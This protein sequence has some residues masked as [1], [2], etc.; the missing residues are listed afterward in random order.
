[1]AM[2]TNYL[3]LGGLSN[4]SGVKSQKLFSLGLDQAVVRVVLHF[5]M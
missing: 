5:A 3:K 1:M 4:S 2:V